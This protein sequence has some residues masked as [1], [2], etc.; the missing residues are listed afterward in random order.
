MTIELTGSILIPKEDL[1]SVLS[2]LPNHIQLTRRESGCLSF[3]VIQDTEQTN[4]FH[5]RETF[6]DQAAFEHHQL[7]TQQ[8][9]WA[10]ITSKATRNYQTHVLP[11]T[12]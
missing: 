1:A 6:V 11:D 3:D 9:V 10:K 7:R 8:S 5:V 12:Q 4:L 2:E